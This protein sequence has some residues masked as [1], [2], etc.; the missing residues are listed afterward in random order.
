MDLHGFDFE[1]CTSS[2]MMFQ[3]VGAVGLGYSGNDVEVPFV[4]DLGDWTGNNLLIFYDTFIDTGRN[5]PNG[6]EIIFS[7]NFNPI[8]LRH[9]RYVFHFFA[10]E[11]E[12]VT[13]DISGWDLSNVLD[14]SYMF[15]DLGEN[16]TGTITINARGVT[17]PRLVDAGSM[18]F[19]I[20]ASNASRVVINAPD[21]TFDNATNM[22]YMF[23]STCGHSRT[24]PDTICDIN[25]KIKSP[26]VTN[27]RRMFHGTGNLI[28]SPDLDLSEFDTSSVTNMEE[29]FG[30]TWIEKVTEK[31]NFDNFDTSN[32]SSMVSMFSDVQVS[33]RNTESVTIDL[34]H[35]NTPSLTK[36]SYFLSLS[37]VYTPDVTDP[38]SI[39]YVTIDMSN[40]DFSNVTDITGQYSRLLHF[41][42]DI[43]KVTVYVKD[44]A[45][46]DFVENHV[47]IYNY[48]EYNYQ[49]QDGDVVIK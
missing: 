20:G 43:E 39:K 8:N 12:N 48:P 34:S 5:H 47:I 37:K 22:S 41:D 1:R 23:A 28:G 7:D 13:I 17:T 24:Y 21:L 14:A 26:K 11:T 27:M 10:A 45:A 40:F 6:A 35:F 42:T 4:L 44:Q 49:F 18:F 15:A 3:K 32:V 16:S 2:Q 29:M 19:N 31:V 46:K 36:A 33:N 38:Y 30:Y 9:A 25:M